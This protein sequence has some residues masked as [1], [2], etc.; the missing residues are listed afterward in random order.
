MTGPGHQ[1]Q[2]G[3]PALFA[4]FCG[5][6]TIVLAALAG[7]IPAPAQDLSAADHAAAVAAVTAA[8]AGNWSQAYA[9]AGRSS[10]PLA[11]KIVRWLEI[12]RTSPVGRFAEISQ[13]ID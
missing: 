6:V 3:R 2:L 8:R 4:R 5:L 13:F 12:A 9:Q 10:D 1:Q 7:V 11:L